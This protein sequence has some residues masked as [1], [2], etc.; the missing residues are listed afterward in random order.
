MS[1]NSK[2][3]WRLKNPYKDA[4]L[5][6]KTHAKAR[7][8]PFNLT[9]EDFMNT[10]GVHD[11]VRLKGRKGNDLTCDR[12]LPLSKE[13]RGYV[14]GNIQFITNRANAAKRWKEGL[15]LIPEPQ[16]EVPF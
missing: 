12:I 8:I 10:E 4:L 15:D 6:I 1:S 9:F 5:N 13:P 14:G 3:Q 16:I 11:Y 2:R 7:N